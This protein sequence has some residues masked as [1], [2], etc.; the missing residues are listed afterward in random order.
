M[1]PLSLAVHPLLRALLYLGVLLLDF[2]HV[3]LARPDHHLLHTLGEY[4]IRSSLEHHLLV[5][6]GLLVFVFDLTVWA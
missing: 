1:S 2:Q 6:A 3:R 5:H 4:L